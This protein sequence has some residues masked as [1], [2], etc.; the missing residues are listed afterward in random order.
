M[1]DSNEPFDTS[2]ASACVNMFCFTKASR[3]KAKL[4]LMLLSYHWFRSKLMVL[5]FNLST[6]YWA[7]FAIDTFKVVPLTSS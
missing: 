6:M 5:L 7:S 2:C 1:A 4:A 3:N